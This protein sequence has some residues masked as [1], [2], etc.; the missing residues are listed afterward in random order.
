LTPGLDL[1]GYHAHIGSQVFD[2]DAFELTIKTLTSFASSVRDKHGFVPR[3]LSPGGGVGISYEATDPE[4]DF[5]AWA[6]VA[7]RTLIE[8]CE[9]HNLPLPELV[10]E[11]GRSIVG[12]AAV[13]VYTVG[14]IKVIPNIR[15]YISVDGGMADN[16]RPSLYGARYS[17]EVANRRVQSTGELVTV[18]GKYCE[19]GDILIRDVDIG[20]VTS[21]DLIAIPAVG[22]YSL[23]MASNYNLALRP[24]VVMVRDGQATVIRRRE[25][26]EDLLAHE[27]LPVKSGL[28]S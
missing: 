1:V 2:L 3:V 24:A 23:A 11:P 7:A 27:V 20:D 28:S 17:A 13:A 21:G 4:V 25:R 16:I 6:G 5:S 9:Q 10:V 22:A 15:T 8:G 19:S 26:Y 18:A 12:P 14:A